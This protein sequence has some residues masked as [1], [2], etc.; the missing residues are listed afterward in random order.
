[1]PVLAR[2]HDAVMFPLR[3]EIESSSPPAVVRT[4]ADGEEYL[5]T[6]AGMRRV[7]WRVPTGLVHAADLTGEAAL[8]GMPLTSL[9]EFG[10]SRFPFERVP[11]EERCSICDE[12]AGSPSV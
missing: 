7:E 11:H 4:F 2:C 6:W 3:F 10:R 9:E 1:M 8:C 5:R 12:A